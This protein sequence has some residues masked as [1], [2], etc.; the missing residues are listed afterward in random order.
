M[1]LADTQ[2]LIEKTEGV[3]TLLVLR[4]QRQFLVSVPEV[5]ESQ[6]QSDSSQLDGE[7]RGRGR[8]P[9][10]KCSAEALEGH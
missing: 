5:E 8:E 7:G 6:S 2:Q 9:G 1:S 10:A 4:D 3:L